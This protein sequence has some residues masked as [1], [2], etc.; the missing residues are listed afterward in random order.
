L[1]F[2]HEIFGSPGRNCINA[3]LQESPQERI[4]RVR[5]RDRGHVM[6][7]SVQ[8]TFLDMSRST[9]AEPLPHV[10]WSSVMLK[11]QPLPRRPSGCSGRTV[12]RE[13]LFPWALSLSGSN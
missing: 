5:F 13:S 10:R 4:H 8:F 6:A 9:I 1:K 3:L 11:L 7:Y 2:C 12:K